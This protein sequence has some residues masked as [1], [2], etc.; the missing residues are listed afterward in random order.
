MLTRIAMLCLQ[1]F[2]EYKEIKINQYIFSCKLNTTGSDDQRCIHQ[3]DI[4]EKESKSDSRI[5]KSR[6]IIFEERRDIET[7]QLIR[8]PA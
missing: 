2:R 7:K 6:I 8:L 4:D 1:V 3:L 5:Q